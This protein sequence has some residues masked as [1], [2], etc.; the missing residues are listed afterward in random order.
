MAMIAYFCMEVGLD[1]AMPTYSGGLGVLA[2]DTLLTAADLGIPMVGV[3]L[4]HRKGHFRQR[5]DAAGNQTEEPASWSPEAF[6]Q[7]LAA[8]AV[9]AIEGRA[10]HVRPWRLAIHGSN[11][12]TVPVYFLDT[13]LPE[14]SPEDR[15]LTDFLYGGDGNYRLAQ[16]AIL[17]FGGVALLRALGHDVRTYHMNESHTALLVVGLLEDQTQ[18][19][20][21]DKVTEADAQMIRERCVFTTHTPVAEGHDQ[22]SFDMVRQILGSD[23]A[24]FFE[25]HP[26][27][28]DGAL[29]MTQLAL[30]FSRYINGV[31]MRHAEV[32]R[33]L[34]P[35]HSI[36]SITNGVHA[37]RWAADSFRRLYD[38][39]FPQWR[40]D[41][42]YLRYAIGIP[43]DEIQQAH[44]EAKG[45]LLAEIHR[46]TGVQL[47]RDVLTLGFARRATGYKR[48]DLLFSDP[49]HL[50]HI[51]ERAGRVQVIYAGKAHARDEGGK[52][53]IRRVF[54]AAGVLNGIVPVLY[55][56]DYDVD[57]AAQICAGVD[58]WLNTPQKPREASGT[59]GMKAALNGVPSFSVLDGWWIEGCV[60]GVT[61]WSIGDGPESES[62]PAL[63]IASLYG[64][65]EHD[66]LPT[67]Y[68]RPEH[69]RQMMRWAIAI[70][71]AYLNTHRMLAQYARHA[72][73]AGPV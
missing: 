43:L 38:K 3:T 73:R 44:T 69:F 31:S 67:F 23:R 12:H 62:N 63:E 55:L 14:N 19:R 18:G 6:L 7:P 36:N 47:E 53:L 48:A 9:V 46:R 32:S 8:R 16:E 50:R 26:S 59:S 30:Y 45:M 4:L 17:G 49:E 25:T 42:Q 2:G 56:Q 1:R 60:E 66:V 70:N 51:V 11:E 72:Y 35:H 34:Y 58:I 71:G 13:D 39:R 40:R 5:L 24:A 33:G 65:L 57:L 27:C 54:E 21:L 22:F 28:R 64:K 41:H 20:G 10:V 29:N 52:Q 15:S 37:V 68:E 61:G